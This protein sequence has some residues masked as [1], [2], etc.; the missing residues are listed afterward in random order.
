VPEFAL[1][2]LLS[3]LFLAAGALVWGGGALLIDVW[4]CRHPRV[5]LADRL[6]TLQPSIADEAE[7]W[8]REQ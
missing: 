8:L 7:A 2:V 1:A 6:A 5:D 3:P 4:R